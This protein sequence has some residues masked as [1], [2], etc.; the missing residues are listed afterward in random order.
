MDSQTIANWIQVVTGVAVLVGLGLVVWE[1]RQS[2]DATFSQ[3][4]SEY[5][6]FASQ[7]R[8][9]I[10]GEDAAHVLAKACHKPTE[11][12]ESDLVILEQ[13]YSGFIVRIDRMMR[14]RERGGFYGS[15]QWREAIPILDM[16]FMSQPG[17]AYWASVA[18]SWVDPEIHAA[19]NEYLAEWNLR[20]CNEDHSVWMQAIRQ[21]SAN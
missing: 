20:M 8:A 4:S 3:L 15:D 11:L 7:E 18:P 1:L 6:H 21:L 14:L 19:G 12:T 9:A 10:F 2:R 17:R 16:L 13:Y 5:W